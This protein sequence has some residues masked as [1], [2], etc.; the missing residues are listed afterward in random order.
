MKKLKLPALEITPQLIEII[1]KVAK[2][3]D[4]DYNKT[5]FWLTTKNPSFGFIAPL[6]L[7]RIGRG[8]KVLEFVNLAEEENFPKVS[9]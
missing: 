1:V 3:F 2:I 6:H 5:K 8:H 9:R 4:G 7:L